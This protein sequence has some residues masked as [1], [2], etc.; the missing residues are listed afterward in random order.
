MRR[1][2]SSSTHRPNHSQ[3]A[4]FILSSLLGFVVLL[5][6]SFLLSLTAPTY[7]TPIYS[8]YPPPEFP[9]SSS[10]CHCL[11]TIHISFFLRRSLLFAS[12][13]RFSF[14]FTLL[15]ILAGDIETNPGP[16]PAPTLIQFVHLYCIYNSY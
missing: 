11:N 8:Q 10:V 9:I 12:P 7:R 5:S 6:F 3:I 4:S 15:L 14:Y 16:A 1:L 2:N 13:P